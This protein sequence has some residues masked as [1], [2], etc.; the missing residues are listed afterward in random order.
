[1]SVEQYFGRDLEA[2]SVARNY[3]NWIIHEF[4]PYFGDCVAEVGAGCGNFS[5]FLLETAIK[6][7]IAFEPSENMY[8]LLHER[9]K[10]NPKVETVQGYFGDHCNQYTGMLDAALYV[11]VM[12]HVPDDKAELA[13][14]HGALKKGGHVLIF[15]PALQWLYSDFDKRI[16]HYR[17]YHKK[18]LAELVASSGFTV[19]K[20]KYMDATGILPWLI[21]F[22]LFK[23]SMSSGKV[24]LYDT[25]IVPPERFFESLIPPPLGK[26]LLV[27]GRKL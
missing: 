20:I 13:H 25:L 14:I 9:M 7:L 24:S 11:N 17:R 16:G 26:N 27:V 15:V 22:K 10:T 18:A 3:N 21:A 8:T 1:M 23:L 5:T 6:R 4:K 12:E 19:E 2:M